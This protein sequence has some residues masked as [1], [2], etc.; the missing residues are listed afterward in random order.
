MD[1]YS[2]DQA[3][4]RPTPTR[5]ERSLSEVAIDQVVFDVAD[6]PRKHWSTERATKYAE[7]MKNGDIFPPI[8]IEL[9]TNKLI[10]GKHRLEAH[11]QA[12]HQTIEVIF[13]EI[14][15]DTT[16]K[17]HAASLSRTHGDRITREE[18]KAIV[19][20]IAMEN[21]EFSQEVLARDSG[22]SQPTISRWLQE[23]GITDKKKE[24]EEKARELRRIRVFLLSEAGWSQRNIADHLGVHHSTVADDIQVNT[25]RQ[26]TEAQMWD[27]GVALDGVIDVNAII[28]KIMTSRLEHINIAFTPIVA[29]G[30]MN[31]NEADKLA[32][33]YKE[34]RG[35]PVHRVEIAE[36]LRAIARKYTLVAEA[37][38]NPESM[39][40]TD[41]DVRF[42]EGHA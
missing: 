16:F 33:K 8:V 22:Y 26:Y 1:G 4:E 21:P 32:V 37:V 2:I 28:A 17:L 12:G 24:A 35:D 39:T 19:I 38:E 25:T 36:S 27:A 42:L 15:Q 14:P 5:R 34:Y 18:M 31:V 10:D 40:L 6:Y 13:R 20:E 9:G 3:Y 29:K 30:H 23:A 7:E 11:R 41:D